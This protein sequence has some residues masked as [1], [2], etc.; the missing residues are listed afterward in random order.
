MI[1][2][3]PDGPE[4]EAGISQAEADRLRELARD[5]RVLEIGSAF[6]GSTIAMASTAREVVAVDPHQWIPGSVDVLRANLAAYGLTNVR[7]VQELS[8]TYLPALIAAGE[9]FDLV[10]IDGDHSGAAVALDAANARQLAPVLAFHDYGNAEI[11]VQPALDAAFP[12]DRYR[13]HLV[14]ALLTAYLEERAYVRH[15]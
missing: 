6:G 1:Q 2:P 8:F 9:K 12:P 14:G 13:R 7:I 3:A 10:Y 5:K 11:E 4:I 15:I